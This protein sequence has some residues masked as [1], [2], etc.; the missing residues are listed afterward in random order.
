[1]TNIN[2]FLAAHP[3]FILT[4]ATSD[5]ADYA[6][7]LVGPYGSF[8]REHRDLATAFANLEEFC[9]AFA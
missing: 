8:S 1:M 7:S 5:Y 2:A 6:V 3:S 4:V 9:A